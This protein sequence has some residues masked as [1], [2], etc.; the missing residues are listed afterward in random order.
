MQHAYIP[1]FPLISL[2]KPGTEETIKHLLKVT[3]AQGITG[4]KET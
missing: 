1:V 4:R 2:F 3:D